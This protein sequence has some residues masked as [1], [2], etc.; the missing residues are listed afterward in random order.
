MASQTR[1]YVKPSDA[2]AFAHSLLA[3]TGLPDGH[4]LLMA[5]CLVQA[6][7]RGV[8]RNDPDRMHLFHIDR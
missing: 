8:V 6:D 5:K 2:E 7:T 4:A 3:K 1:Y